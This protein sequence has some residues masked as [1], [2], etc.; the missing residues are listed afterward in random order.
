MGALTLSA[1]ALLAG[2]IPAAAAEVRVSATPITEFAGVALD[3]AVDGLI[4]RGGVVLTSASE[5]FGGLSG[6]TFTG[7]DHR[8]VFVSDRGSFVSGRF[9]YDGQ[10]RLTGFSD[11]TIAPMRNT[12]GQPLPR[13]YARDAEGVDTVYRNGEP[14]AV[15]VSFENLTRVVDYALSD[16]VPGGAAIELPLP[17]WLSELRTNSSLESV[18]VA[19]PMSPVAGSTVLITEGAYDAEGNHKGW[20][21]GQQDQGPLSYASTSGVNPTECAFLPNGD[22]LVLERGLSLLNFSMNLRRVPAADVRTGVVM[23]GEVLLSASGAAVDNMEAM[24]VYIAPSGE[25]RIVIGSD[26]NFSGFQ[27]TMLLEFGVPE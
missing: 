25:T 11:V 10:Q 2:V 16:G 14:V 8:V 27:R 7:P 15:R 4:W 17:K 21:L 3:Q 13:Q 19:P 9:T 23:T 1:L 18:C 22:L 5:Q 6:L 12:K 26:D 24:A 20:L